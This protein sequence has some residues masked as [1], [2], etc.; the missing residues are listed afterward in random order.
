MPRWGVSFRQVGGT[1][2]TPSQPRSQARN[3][4]MHH[5]SADELENGAGDVPGLSCGHGC[6]KADRHASLLPSADLHTRH[7]CRLTQRKWA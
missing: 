5:V 1:H 7:S 4:C 6:S 2:P 3:A